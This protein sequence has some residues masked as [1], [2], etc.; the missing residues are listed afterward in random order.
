MELKEEWRPCPEYEDYYKVSNLGRVKSSAIFIRHDGNWAEE[1]G[2]VKKIKP[3][4]QHMNRYGYMAVKLCKLGKCRQ[5]L[6]HRLVALA[7]LPFDD[8]RGQVNHIDGDKT[9]NRVDNLEWVTGKENMK[10]AWETGLVNADHL[11]GSKHH[12]AKLNEEK[13]LEIRKLYADKKYKQ[14]ELA[15]LYG[16]S[17]ATLKDVL[18]HRTWKNI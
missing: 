6:V 11:Q 12:N 7:F 16:I 5:R 10:H 18:Y 1:G 9:N 13:V 4:R 17:I 3:H 8:V 2:Y 14:K 15:E